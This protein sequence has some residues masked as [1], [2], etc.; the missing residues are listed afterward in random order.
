M[1][2][3][4]DMRK[5][6]LLV[7]VVL[8][9]VSC[10]SSRPGGYVVP[11]PRATQAK[12]SA[13]PPASLHLAPSA[14][15]SAGSTK[16]SSAS[17]PPVRLSAP[18]PT[19][20]TATP[21][22]TALPPVK[23]SRPLSI[24]VEVRSTRAASVYLIKPGDPVVVHL[25][26]IPQ[27]QEIEDQVDEMGKINLPFINEMTAAGKSSSELE[28]EIRSAYID[29]QIYKNIMVNVILPSQS[30][31]VRGEVRQPGRFPLSSGVTM[32]QAIAAAGGYTE[33]ANSKKV[34]LLRGNKADYYDARSFE[35]HPEKDVAIEA[36]DVIVVHRSVF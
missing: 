18:A 22:T 27:E 17:M 19:S 34:Q 30:Y 31:F 21:K 25:R 28:K 32:V 9:M 26:G 29:Q 6:L 33:F 8:S 11:P 24:P 4:V 23:A 3:G 15:K 36:G 20:T 16:Q 35:T 10:T 13:L 5:G 7:L 2:D 14:D 12:P 1:R